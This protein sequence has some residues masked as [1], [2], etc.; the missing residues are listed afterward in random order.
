MQYDPIEAYYR[1]QLN[2]LG[3]ICF[4]ANLFQEHITMLKHIYLVL[5]IWNGLASTTKE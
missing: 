2:I 5:T 4:E 1:A 3:I